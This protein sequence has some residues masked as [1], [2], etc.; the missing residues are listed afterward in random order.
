MTSAHPHDAQLRSLYAAYLD[1]WNRRSG[2]AV[3]AC[4]AD[5]GDI[6]GYDGTHHHG[7]KRGLFSRLWKQSKLRSSTRAESSRSAGN[8]S[9]STPGTN[10]LQWIV[11]E[12]RRAFALRAQSRRPS[13]KF[14]GGGGV[15]SAARRGSGVAV[16][17]AR[18]TIFAKT[19]DAPC[20]PVVMRD[21]GDS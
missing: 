20:V 16:A 8:N 7:R 6:V 14:A 2:A 11:I 3:A 12:R 1:G 9:S 15:A 4:F 13:R 17:Q 19:R 18:P 5:D 10:R 21:G